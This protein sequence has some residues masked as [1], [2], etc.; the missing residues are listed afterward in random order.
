MPPMVRILPRLLLLY[1][2]LLGF[3]ASGEPPREGRFLIDRWQPWEKA[4]RGNPALTPGFWCDRLYVELSDRRS[5][6]Q[7]CQTHGVIPRRGPKCVSDQ[8]VD[9]NFMLFADFGCVFDASRLVDTSGVRGSAMAS[10]LSWLAPLGCREPPSPVMCARSW[11]CRLV[12]WAGSRRKR[13]AGR[14][15]QDMR[16]SD[17]APRR[18]G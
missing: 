16:G 2:K 15:R 9:E 13:S 7:K 4:M 1:L 6:R 8:V 14:Q 10:G 11:L 5:D 18:R 17:P 3:I 12:R